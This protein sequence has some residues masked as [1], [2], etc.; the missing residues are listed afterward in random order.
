MV[1]GY[2]GEACETN[3]PFAA[4]LTCAGCHLGSDV[5]NAVHAMGR[6]GAPI[7]EHV[8]LPPVHF[9]KLSCTSCH[10]GAW[11]RKKTILAKTSMAHALGM[12]NVSKSDSLMPH[13]QS[14]VF[15]KSDQGKITPHYLFWP[16]YW[17][18]HIDGQYKP[19]ELKTAQ[20]VI[21]EVISH[22][23]TLGTGSWPTISDSLILA[24][25]DS[26]QDAGMGENELAYISG[27]Y[28]YTMVDS[29]RLVA[30]HDKS[31]KPYIWPLAHDVRPATQSLG[32]NGCNDCHTINSALYFSRVDRDTPFKS[33]SALTIRMSIFMKESPVAAW[34]FSF[35]FFFRPLLKFM[36]LGSML[37]I[38]AILILSGLNGLS[39]IIHLVSDDQKN[40]GD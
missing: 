3:Q 35:S 1:R 15:Y 21:M 32:I 13:I 7:P 40:Q 24:V 38:T 2:E 11:P 29:G 34:I 10:S 36:I 5:N 30:F 19:M 17:A 20:P 28:R 23:D 25:F 16:A 31:L 22:S 12:H 27:G 4:S 6:L 39:R 26:L 33:E 14:P 9:E 8:G 37:L 18:E